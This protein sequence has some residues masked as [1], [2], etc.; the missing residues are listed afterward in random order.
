MQLYGVLIT[1]A[2][3]Q[4][5]FVC[6]SVSNVV[7]NVVTNGNGKDT[8]NVLKGTMRFGLGI[9]SSLALAKVKLFSTW[10]HLL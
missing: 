1:G 2:V 10:T 6:A 9:V 4:P 3:S 5:F 7:S 8:K